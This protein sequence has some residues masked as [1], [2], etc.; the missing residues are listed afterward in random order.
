LIL[1]ALNKCQFKTSIH[2]LCPAFGC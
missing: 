2:V 1:A